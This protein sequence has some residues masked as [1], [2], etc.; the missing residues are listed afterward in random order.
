[1]S[2]KLSNQ[3][4]L[5]IGR[6]VP[7]HFSDIRHEGIIEDKD[8]LLQ[9]KG[10]SNYL[11]E[12]ELVKMEGEWYHI[13]GIKIN[14]EIEFSPDAEFE[15]EQRLVPYSLLSSWDGRATSPKLSGLNNHH[16]LLQECL[17]DLI[18]APAHMVGLKFE[19]NSLRAIA[20]TSLFC[21]YLRMTQTFFN[22]LADHG[23]SFKIVDI[24]D[25][26]H[27]TVYEPRKGPRHEDP[28]YQDPRILLAGT[29][30]D[31]ENFEVNIKPVRCML[32]KRPES[33][34]L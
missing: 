15:E 14:S 16:E 34:P 8:W 10:R 30:L 18:S 12:W 4:C 19:R 2:M 32:T 22:S 23:G 28:I 33:L 6:A 9:A 24:D 26:N 5:I 31:A 17:G 3:V 29:A 1:M 21:H 11:P 20:N 7:D 25:R 27:F 13:D